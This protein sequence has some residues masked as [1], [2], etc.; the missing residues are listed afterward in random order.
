MV[1]IQT[2]NPDYWAESSFEILDEDIEQLF[3]FLLDEEEPQSID[4]MAQVIMESRINAEKQI[5]QRRLEGRKVYQPKESYELGA[6]VIFPYMHFA[7]GEVSNIR[8][9]HN[10]QHGKFKAIEVTFDTGHK[11]EYAAE[12]DIEHPLNNGSGLE[13]Q[14]DEDQDLQQLFAQYGESV[15]AALNKKLVDNDEFVRLANEWFVKSLFVDVNVGHLHLSEAVLEMNGG[16]PLPPDEMIVHLDMDKDTPLSVKR[17]S[18]N[19]ALLNDN[20]FD[21]VAPPGEVAWFLKRLAPQAVRDVPERLDYDSLSFDRALLGSQ[22]LHIERELDDEWSSLDSVNVGGGGLKIILTYPHRMS[23]TLPLSSRVKTLFPLGKAQNQLVTLIDDETNVEYKAWVV[24][25]GRYI[26]GLGEWYSE[27]GVLAGSY[28][29]LTPTD[30]LG[31][32]L[33]GYD[34]R[35]KERKEWIRVAYV[36]DGR[37]RFELQN[38]N[39]GSDFDDLMVVDTDSAAA[40]DVIYKKSKQRPIAELLAELFP[41]LTKDSAQ[42]AVH[43]KTLYSIVNLLR[44]AP[45]GLVFAELVRQPAFISV[46]DQFWQFDTNKWQN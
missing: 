3:Q 46:G 42:N 17:F 31:R 33:I 43:A 7:H 45:S 20:R 13:D 23:G 18:L 10:P 9:A 32:V 19:Y 41:D 28:I 39:V 11:S 29:N 1:E 40:L 14:V 6:S 24:S 15:V 16:G 37:I 8:D 44:R 30:R 5:L 22:L 2:R 25:E 4:V 12:L 36:D 26:T 38:R 34:R 35:K 27:Q 21:E